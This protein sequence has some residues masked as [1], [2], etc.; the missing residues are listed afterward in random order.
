MIGIVDLV[1][2]NAGRRGLEIRSSAAEELGVRALSEDPTSIGR[3]VYGFL[4]LRL[5]RGPGNVYFPGLGSPFLAVSL[6]SEERD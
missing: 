2:L 3:G 6:D 5:S 1:P 4:S